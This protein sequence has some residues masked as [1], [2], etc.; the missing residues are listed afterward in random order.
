MKKI[1]KKLDSQFNI[2]AQIICGILLSVFFLTCL[3]Y[4]VKYANITHVITFA[5]VL[6]MIILLIVIG[7]LLTLNGIDELLSLPS[8]D[9]V[10]HD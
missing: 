1:T 5:L 6:F 9:K 10:K 8:D 4:F 3:Y 2:I 7:I